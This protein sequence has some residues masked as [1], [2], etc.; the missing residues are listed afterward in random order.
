MDVWSKARRPSTA[1]YVLKMEMGRLAQND[2]SSAI[3]IFFIHARRTAHF[4]R[5]S[6]VLTRDRF[7]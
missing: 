2:L 5:D 4:L 1:G 6:S 3:H 7:N